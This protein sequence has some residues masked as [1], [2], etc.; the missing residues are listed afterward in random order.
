MVLE[1]FSGLNRILIIEYCEYSL[2]TYI[3]IANIFKAQDFYFN[4]NRI[5][6][7]TD[8]VEQ[9]KGLKVRPN[10]YDL[11]IK[12]LLWG[13]RVFCHQLTQFFKFI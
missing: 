9:E 1:I 4:Y 6:N 7:L 2:L 8:L 11:I 10:K 5:T 13:L 12:G 3:Q